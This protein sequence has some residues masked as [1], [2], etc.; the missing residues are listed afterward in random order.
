MPPVNGVVEILP[1]EELVQEIR[2]E[3]QDIV[4]PEV[5]PEPRPTRVMTRAA[6][7]PISNTYV[8]DDIMGDED[9]HYSR[10]YLYRKLKEQKRHLEARLEQINYGLDML[11]MR[12][13]SPTDAYRAIHEALYD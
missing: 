9:L 7:L 12:E 4:L 6:R 2:E 10:N 5:A 1:D 3:T 11:D 8:D 13:V